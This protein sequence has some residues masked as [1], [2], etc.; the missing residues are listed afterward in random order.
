[1]PSAEHSWVALAG[2]AL[3]SDRSIAVDSLRVS[4]LPVSELNRLRQEAV[5]HLS[6]RFD[7][8]ATADKLSGSGGSGTPS[9]ESRRPPT[10]WV[11]D[12]S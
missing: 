1:M 11:R 10:D 8:M 12:R 4:V 2:L 9:S 5:A 3:R 7:S 6:A